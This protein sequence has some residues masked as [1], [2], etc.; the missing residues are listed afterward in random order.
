MS[1]SA[2]EATDDDD[3]SQYAP[4][5]MPMPDFEALA[6]DIQ[7]RA[8]RR[9]GAVTTETRHFRE[10]FGTSVLIVEKTWELLER[11]SLLPKGGRPKHLLWALH[12]MMG[13]SFYE[14][15]PQAEPGVFGH[16]RVCQRSRTEDP[17]QVGLGV[18]HC[19]CQPGQ[20]G[21]WW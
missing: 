13:P 1:V 6:R 3:Y 21:V 5:H 11:D 9:V 20:C 19:H 7:N 10:F 12:F 15:V 18:Y 14:G 2:S 17:P 16:Q 4:G 8:S